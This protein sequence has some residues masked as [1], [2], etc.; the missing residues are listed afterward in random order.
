MA[1][2]EPLKLMDRWSDTLNFA[3]PKSGS[4][5]LHGGGHGLCPEDDKFVQFRRNFVECGRRALPWASA[6]FGRVNVLIISCGWKADDLWKEL[7]HVTEVSLQSRA[8][9][10]SARICS[11]IDAAQC[12]WFTGGDQSRLRGALRGTRMAA[13]LQRLLQRQG[14][15]G[16]AAAGASLL[17]ALCPNF[18]EIMEG[19][20]LLQGLVLSHLLRRDRQDRL[21]AIADCFRGMWCWGLDEAAGMVLSNK[22]VH[23]SCRS[24]VLAL[25]H[26]SDGCMACLLPPGFQGGLKE[27]EEQMCDL[28]TINWHPEEGVARG[29]EIWS[30]Q[31]AAQKAAAD[32]PIQGVQTNASFEEVQ[33]HQFLSWKLPE[34][35]EETHSALFFGSHC[36]LSI[37]FD[38]E[39]LPLLCCLLLVQCVGEGDRVEIKL[40]D[41]LLGPFDP[42]WLPYKFLAKAFSIPMGTLRLGSNTLRLA[43]ADVKS[44]YCLLSASLSDSMMEPDSWLESNLPATKMRRRRFRDLHVFHRSVV[45][46]VG[47]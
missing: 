45:I 40:N 17:C 25:R 33:R 43:T 23:V 6:L 9:A 4:I 18:D 8:E 28:H 13:A 19:L 14:A 42:P 2:G 44:R 34:D 3:L 46:R 32:G 30:V 31:W 39:D 41:H 15:V 16:G 27:V 11:L 37:C 47:S 35:S 20:D 12:V 22:K 10:D 26:G 7:G 38:L 21:A 29:T 36:H 24:P 1:E 5:H